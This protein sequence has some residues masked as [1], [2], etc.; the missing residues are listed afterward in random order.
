M[1]CPKCKKKVSKLLALSRED[2]KTMICD[3]CGILEALQDWENYLI[4]HEEAN[5]ESENS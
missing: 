3:A 4:K 5:N 1:I 2:N